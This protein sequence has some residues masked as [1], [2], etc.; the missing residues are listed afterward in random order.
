MLFD[1]H[2]HLDASQFDKDRSQVIE[3]ARENG[4]AFIMNPGADYASSVAAL[5]LAKTYDFIYAAVGVHPH[6]AETVTP[7]LMKK[8]EELARHEKVRAIGEIGLDYYR[9]LSPRSIQ[10]TVFREQIQLAKR[11]GLPIIIHDR[12]ANQDVLELLKL[13]SAFDTGV[14]MHCFSGSHE[15]A[16]QYVKLGAFISIAGPVTFK[17][18][19]KTVEVVERIGLDRLM[20]ETDA[21]YL[22]PEPNRG[23]R[24]EPAYVRHTCSKIASILNV[25]EESVAQ[26]TLENAKIFFSIE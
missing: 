16:V 4:V 12:D 26:K 7:D 6:D 25:S 23:K 24:N 11:L 10:K 9:D 18:A 3:R 22:T 17:N 1:S 19:R 14:L 8:L 20:I 15:L 21:P 5:E 13:E 2:A